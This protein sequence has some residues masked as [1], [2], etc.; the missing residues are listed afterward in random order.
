[1]K[2]ARTSAITDIACLM[3]IATCSAH[4]FF[5]RSSF[6]LVIVV[7]RKKGQ[8]SKPVPEGP[9]SGHY[10]GRTAA[11]GPAPTVMF[12]IVLDHRHRS[13]TPEHQG[14]SDSFKSNSV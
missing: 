11:N 8:L 4:L 3:S 1:M 10:R 12:L 9:R 6:F 13:C 2:S 5:A 7:A 14:S